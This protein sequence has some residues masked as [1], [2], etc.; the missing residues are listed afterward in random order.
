MTDGTHPLGIALTAAPFLAYFGMGLIFL[1]AY[2]RT[3]R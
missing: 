1:L 2:L 3:D